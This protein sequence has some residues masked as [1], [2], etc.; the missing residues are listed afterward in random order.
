ME[1]WVKSSPLHISQMSLYCGLLNMAFYMVYVI[2]DDF[3]YEKEICSEN[4]LSIEELRAEKF[5]VF[6]MLFRPWLHA[7]FSFFI[8]WRKYLAET[9]KDV[10]SKNPLNQKVLHLNTSLRFR[11]SSKGKSPNY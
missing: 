10:L 8:S 11:K 7:L 4:I 9:G 6:H 3:S 1:Q 5:A 2:L